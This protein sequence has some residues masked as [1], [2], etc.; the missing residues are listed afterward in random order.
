VEPT[1]HKSHGPCPHCGGEEQTVWGNVY[2]PSQ[3]RA[4]YYVRWTAG[5]RRENITFLVSV[6]SWTSDNPSDRR[7]VGLACRLR[8]GWPGFMVID[9][10]RTPWGLNGDTTVLG[11]MLPRDEVIGTQLAAEVFQ[12]V[13]AV[14][15]QD[16]RVRE[17]LRSGVGL[18]GYG[19][20]ARRWWQF[21][22]RDVPVKSSA[23]PA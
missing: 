12:V 1:L 19:V 22:R 15:V 21:W 10:A 8:R 5:R 23:Q 4:V 9:A 14:I 13:D 6:G 2:A 7:S 11:R 18:D 17:F 20:P 3:Q 16:P